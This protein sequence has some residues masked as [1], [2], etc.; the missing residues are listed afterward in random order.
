[1][2]KYHIHLLAAAAVLFLLLPMRVSADGLNID[3]AGNVA[4]VS[5][6][7]AEDGISSLQFSLAVEAA[8]G[9][10]VEFQFLGSARVQEYRYDG[11]TGRMNV[12]IAG[13]EALFLEGT[14][15][16]AVGKIL[17]SDGTGSA[18]AAVSVVEDSLLYVYGT[19]LVTATDLE[20]PGKVQI[21]EASQPVVTPPPVTSPPTDPTEST[22]EPTQTPPPTSNPDNTGH[23]GNNGN[24]GNTG[25]QTGTGAEGSAGSQGGTAGNGGSHGN[26]GSNSGNSNG[27]GSLSGSSM[28]GSSGTQTP[29]AEPSDIPGEPEGSTSEADEDPGESG[30]DF[31]ESGQISSDEDAEREEE[32]DDGGISWLIFMVAG[33]ALLLLGVAVMAVAVLKRKPKISDIW[34]E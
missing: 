14:D 23:Q 3:A 30:E 31:S 10:Q 21:G 5:D 16:L 17:V 13:T 8:S 24:Q 22:P 29:T 34:D 26:A 11:E 19:D 6:H 20:I 18:S 7:A 9:A 32:P 27:S 12:Y 33:A 1:M 2:R 25:S 4:I 15:T 28:G